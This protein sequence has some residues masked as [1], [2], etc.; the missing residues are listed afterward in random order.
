VQHFGCGLLLAAEGDFASNS[1]FLSF[2]LDRVL[3]IFDFI[4]VDIFIVVAF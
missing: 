3:L 1:G 2:E 4:F